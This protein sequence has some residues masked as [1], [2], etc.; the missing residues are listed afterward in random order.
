MDLLSWRAG[1]GESGFSFVIT[2]FVYWGI[3]LVS[4]CLFK[5]FL[6]GLQTKIEPAKLQYN[7]SFVLITCKKKKRK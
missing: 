7:Y 5:V 1:G 6:S 3:Y 4:A 2:L